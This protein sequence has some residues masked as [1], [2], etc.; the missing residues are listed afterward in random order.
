MKY[1]AKK[2]LEIAAAEIGYIEKQSNS[3]LDNKT[4]NAGNQDFT[5][6]ARDLYA[7][8]Y[9]NGSKMGC[10]WC[11]MFVD[12]VFLQLC[13][14]KKTAQDMSCQTGPY[15]AACYYS[16]KYYEQQGRFVTSDPKPGDQIYFKD[17]GHTGIVEK[18]NGNIITTIEGNTSNRVARKTYNVKTTRIEGYGRPKYDVEYAGE[19][20]G[21][22]GENPAT[23]RYEIGEI[24]DFTGSRHYTNAYSGTGYGCKPGKA[25]ITLRCEGAP[26]PYHLVN[27]DGSESTVYG[28]VDAEDVEKLQTVV[29]TCEVKLP[30]L[31]EGDEGDAV[32]ALQILLNGSNCDCAVDGEFGTETAAALEKLQQERGLTVD[33]VCGAES[34]SELLGV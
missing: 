25:K 34:W 11:N 28:W 23:D 5:K 4:A 26:H 10:A 18:V 3:Q 24:V 7:A 20:A 32:L 6:Y 27:V 16:A 1:T 15:G 19:N 29:R 30:V 12:W 8:G 17:Y 2:L 14:D 31:Q 21:E 22:S 33:R 9:Y 13:G